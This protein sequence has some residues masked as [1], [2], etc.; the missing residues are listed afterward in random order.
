MKTELKSLLHE[1]YM[2]ENFT[3]YTITRN[4]TSTKTP[5]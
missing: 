2:E 3:A 5:N 4:S 1:P